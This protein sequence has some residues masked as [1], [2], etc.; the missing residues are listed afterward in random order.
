MWKPRKQ[1]RISRPNI[2]QAF[3]LLILLVI[4]GSA[5]AGPSGMIAWTENQRL[6][7]MRR[8]QVVDLEHERAGL[9][10][11]VEL[12]DPSQTDADLAGQLLRDRLNVA[13]P[14]ELVMLLH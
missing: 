8:A 12:L 14:D 4:G 13:H 7:E 11:R 6:L 10:N 3:V 9:R 5:L 1:S 2:T